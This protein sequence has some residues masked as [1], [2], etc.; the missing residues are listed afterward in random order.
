[1]AVTRR[2]VRWLYRR[3][4]GSKIAPMMDAPLFARLLAANQSIKADH[5]GALQ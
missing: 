2:L 1:M 5:G 3:M 4:F